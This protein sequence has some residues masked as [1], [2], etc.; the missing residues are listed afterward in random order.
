MGLSMHIRAEDVHFSYGGKEVLKGMTL[1]FGRG[2]VVSLLGPNGCGKTTLLKVLMGILRPDKGNVLFEGL[3][4]DELGSRRLA[5]RVAYVPQAHRG[6][7]PYTVLDVVLMGRM[8]HKTFFSR[9]TS[10]DRQTAETMLEKLGIADLRH[11]PYT[12]ISGGERQLVLIARALAQGADTFV[13]D[14]PTTGLDYGNQIRLLEQVV[15]LSEEG[16]TF[17][18]STHFPD[19]ALWVSDRVVLM[20]EGAVAADGTASEEITA[21]SLYG[22]YRIPVRVMDAGSGF[23]VCIPSSP[24]WECSCRKR[25]GE[26]ACSTHRVPCLKPGHGRSA[27]SS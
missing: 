2:E 10:R 19:H 11:T 7:F 9:F 14:E 4:I 26:H 27:T 15:L 17:I 8:P 6:T 20:K 18:Q 16:H 13:M 3:P 24:G 1:S 22:L 5:Q 25:K 21:E 12:Q 23:S